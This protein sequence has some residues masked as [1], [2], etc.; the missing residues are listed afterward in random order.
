MEAGPLRPLHPLHGTVRREKQGSPRTSVQNVAR[1]WP[2][3]T[4]A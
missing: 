3:V 1:P 2:G 4:W